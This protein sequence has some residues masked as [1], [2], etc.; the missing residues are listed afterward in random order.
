MEFNHALKQLQSV[1]LEIN[2]D[3]K[4]DQLAKQLASNSIVVAEFE[5][6]ELDQL[7]KHL[8]SSSI[9][10]AE[11]E[12]N[13]I[14]QL[15]KQLA[16]SSIAVA[17]FEVNELDQLAKHLVVA[18][19]EVNEVDHLAKQLALSSIIVAES[20]VNEINQQAKQPVPAKNCQDNSGNKEEHF[21]PLSEQPQKTRQGGL[22]VLSTL[23]DTDQI[24]ELIRQ[25]KANGAETRNIPE[26]ADEF[27]GN[28]FSGFFSEDDNEAN[29]KATSLIQFLTSH[30]FPSQG[31]IGDNALLVKLDGIVDEVFDVVDTLLS[32]VAT[33]YRNNKSSNN[34]GQEGSNRSILDGEIIASRVPTYQHQKSTTSTSSELPS[35][36]TDVLA[37]I[38][39]QRMAKLIGSSA[40][41]TSASSGHV[42]IAKSNASVLKIDQ[43]VSVNT[44]HKQ[45]MQR[46]RRKQRKQQVSSSLIS[47]WQRFK[48]FFTRCLKP[49]CHF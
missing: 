30:L 26:V 1:H 39:S 38:P 11:S 40:S 33:S 5:V 8:A 27:V 46:R 2:H 20:E 24:K 45:Q 23:S 18:K 49:A 31:C 37:E 17:E 35:S 22:E 44:C 28:L 12:E 4:I 10:V 32:S 36:T 6:N 47:K 14:D 42:K 16:S 34:N 3:S 48:N 7:A 13:E 15:A 29:E 9:V 19:S 21:Q 41:A 43:E 25:F